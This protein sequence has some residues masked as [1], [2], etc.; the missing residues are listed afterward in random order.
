VLGRERPAGSGHSDI[1]P[2]GSSI[3]LSRCPPPGGSLSPPPDFDGEVAGA[4]W[5]DVDPDK[6][7]LTVRHTLSRVDDELVLTEPKTDRSP[8][9]VPLHPGP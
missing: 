2:A 7:E 3:P 5:S 9:R 4:L 1:L 8:R 6:R